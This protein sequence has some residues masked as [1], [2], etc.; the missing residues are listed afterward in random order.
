[1]RGKETVT[2]RSLSIA[3][4]VIYLSPKHGPAQN[5]N[6]AEELRLNM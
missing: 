1:M 5:I 4:L 6:Q 3:A 2:S